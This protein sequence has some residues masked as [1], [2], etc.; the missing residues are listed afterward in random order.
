MSI[1]CTRLGVGSLKSSIHG[2]AIAVVTIF[3]WAGK[4]EAQRKDIG[5]QD[6][7]IQDAQVLGL[8]PG[9]PGQAP[10]SKP[11]LLRQT[12]GLIQ[13]ELT[14]IADL[15]GLEQKQQQS[16]AD[17]A[18]SEW[19]AK[20]NPSIVKRMQEHVY[21]M[22]DLDSLAERLV[23]SWL[24]AVATTE[25]LSK[26]DQELA[27]RMKWRQR[28][29]ISKVLETL[30][31][32]LNLSGVQMD[33]IE[34]IL[35]EKWKDRWYRS[36]EA[37]FDNPSL[38]PVPEIRPSWISPILSDSQKA[39]LV[40]RESQPKFGTVQSSVDS[41][42][43]AIDERFRVGATMSSDS[44]ETDSTVSKKEKA[45]TTGVIDGILR[46]AKEEEEGQ[47]NAKKP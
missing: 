3:V 43:L 40:T 23:R 12:R 38:L 4:I 46:K 26:Y 18:E 8:Q 11:Q 6:V 25:Q 20:T 29:L 24:E 28:A 27:D 21:G 9:L 36:L 34:V 1:A 37:T 44:I 45:E 17:L 13:N 31:A 33:Q 32:K 19:R 7:L 10:H 15:C 2:F 22:I 42:S 16:L 47:V 35:N 14:I 39:A 41:P 5:V 30:E